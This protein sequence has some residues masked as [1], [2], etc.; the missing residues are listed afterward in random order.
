M[1]LLPL[2]PPLPKLAP[3][4]RDPDAHD[5]AVRRSIRVFGCLALTATALLPL[6]V[7]DARPRMLRPVPDATPQERKLRAVPRAPPLRLWLLSS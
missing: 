2:S 1:I 7:A 4:A 5:T 6:Q 3:I